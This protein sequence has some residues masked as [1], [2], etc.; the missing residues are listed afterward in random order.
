MRIL[1]HQNIFLIGPMGAGK[2]TIGTYLAR[3]LKK[4]FYD[5]DQVIEERTGVDIPWIFD[6]EGEEGFRRREIEVIDE[7]TSM[8]GIVL[9]TGGGSILEPLNRQHLAA[10]GLVIYLTATLDQQ[11][12]R[13]EHDRKRPL[14]HDGDRAEV[15]HKLRDE[16]QPLYEEIADLVF[17]TNERNVR[18]V[19]TEVLNALC[20][21]DAI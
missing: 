9:A 10:R 13:V 3:E 18:A 12:Q 4:K 17:D 19:A 11:M 2:T 15:L 20:K 14:I 7:L 21:D 16:R 5:S 8:R 1:D 6:V